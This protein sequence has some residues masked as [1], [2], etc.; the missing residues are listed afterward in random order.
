MHGLTEEER[1]VWWL[2]TTSTRPVTLHSGLD[3]ARHGQQVASMSGLDSE[4]PP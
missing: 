2:L 1:R 4:K 3:F